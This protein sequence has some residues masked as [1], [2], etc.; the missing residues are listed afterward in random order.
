[1]LE[2]VSTIRTSS[3]SDVISSGR[4]Y[5]MLLHTIHGLVPQNGPMHNL[6]IPMSNYIF[7]LLNVKEEVT[8]KSFLFRF[9]TF[10][11]TARSLPAQMKIPVVTK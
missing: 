6:F 11:S 9:V 4:K 7:F 2:A 3:R 10:I 5:D 1:M 8:E